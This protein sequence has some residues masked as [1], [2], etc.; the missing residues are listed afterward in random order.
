M[1]A[2]ILTSFGMQLIPIELLYFQ[3]WWDLVASR[4]VAVIGARNP[5]RNGLARA[6]RIVREL[7]RDDFTVVFGARCWDRPYG[8]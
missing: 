6:R 2:S 8:T 7:V 3:G 1:L 4:S 5:S